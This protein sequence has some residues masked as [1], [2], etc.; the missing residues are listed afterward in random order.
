MTANG[1]NINV[2]KEE[3]MSRPTGEQN[4]MLFEGI[5]RIDSHGCSWAQKNYKQDRLRKI[6]LWGAG[7]GAGMG[8]TAVFWKLIQSCF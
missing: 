7:I 8:F 2:S 3:F 4:W 6:Y 1:L 5:Q